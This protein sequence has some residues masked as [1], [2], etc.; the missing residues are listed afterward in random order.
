MTNEVSASPAAS[1]TPRHWITLVLL[2]LTVAT[3]SAMGT[4]FSPMQELAKLDL[5]LTDLQVSF[6]QGLAVSIPIAL[7]S[8]PIGRLVDRSR[9][10]RLLLALLAVSIAGTW[11]T[12][13][14]RASKRFS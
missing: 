13:F 4:V 14:A 7:L 11:L 3:A 10:T 1:S 6:V 8:L 9:R 12:A 5:Q 2:A